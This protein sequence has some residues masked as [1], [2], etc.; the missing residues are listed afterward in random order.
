MRSSLT[1]SI[2]L[3]FS[4]LSVLFIV[5]Q[6][7]GCFHL[8]LLL[9][10]RMQF[11]LVLLSAS[12]SSDLGRLDYASL[13][14]QALMEIFIEGIENREII[15]GSA[16]E[17]EDIEQWRGFAYS[18]EQPSDT[19]EK[20]F[21]IRWVYLG[22]VGTIDLQWLP[23][24]VQSL[25]IKYNK[26]TGS[27]NLTALPP[28]MQFLGIATNAFSGEI[29]LC[30]LPVGIKVLNLSN[31]QLSGSL[32]LEKLPQSIQALYLYTNRFT[33]S[34]CLQHLPPQ[35]GNLAVSRNELSGAVDLT[36]LPVAMTVLW[37]EQNNL[38][39]KTDFSHLPDALEQLDVSHT[40]LFGEIRARP[41]RTRFYIEHSNV[42]L[43]Q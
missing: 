20:H 16:E 41:G 30:H 15:C 7:M 17:P 19:V 40:N 27:L 13:S 34:V 22:L 18:E 11:N 26:L 21:I 5:D 1:A 35:L 23:S 37:L 42:Q 33:G 14:R 31:N 43:I 25:E 2:E 32:N 28:S 29:D 38:E 9:F 3:T 6:F 39:G 36:R 4:F 10:D 12:D 24:T 8:S